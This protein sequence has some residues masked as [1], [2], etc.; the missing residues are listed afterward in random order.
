MKKTTTQRGFEVF[1]FKDSYH[2]RCSLQISSAAG[3]EARCWLGCDDINLRVF[4]PYTKGW[5]NVSDET[6]KRVLGGPEATSIL[7]NTRMHLTQSQVKKLLPHLK[8]FAKTGE[9]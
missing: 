5:V 8:K 7:G 4:V 3:E 1:N 6:A 9:F 2:E